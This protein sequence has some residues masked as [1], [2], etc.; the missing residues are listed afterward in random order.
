MPK[1]RAADRGRALPLERSP[2][3]RSSAKRAGAKRATAKSLPAADGMRIM[4]GAGHV[5]LVE[6]LA[7]RI[8]ASAS[9][10]PGC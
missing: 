10:I 9:E 3:K 1:S 8:A 2:L 5:N 6:T 7:E 4:V